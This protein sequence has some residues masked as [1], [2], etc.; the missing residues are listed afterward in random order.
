MQTISSPPTADTWCD[1]LIPRMSEQAWLKD[2]RSRFLA[3]SEP[4]ADACGARPADMIGMTEDPFFTRY[5]VEMFR[6]DDRRAIAWGNPIMVVEGSMADAQFRT[7]KAPVLDENGRPVGTVGMTLPEKAEPARWRNWLDLYVRDQ[8][9]RPSRTPEWLRRIR[10]D[11]EVAF[12]TPVSVTAL[13]NGA[14]RHPN[15]VTRAFRRRYGVSPV[16][17]AHRRRV[18]CTARVLATSDLSLSRIAMEAGFA[19][20]SHMTRLFSRY[21]GITPGAYRHAM[22]HATA[23]DG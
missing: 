19:D 12:S 3:V 9:P 16:E 20:Q 5:W 11:L 18:E 22:R 1:Q 6:D 23:I 21:F 10:S 14:G 4:F 7:F 2:V 15:Y 8:P 13:A 17:Y